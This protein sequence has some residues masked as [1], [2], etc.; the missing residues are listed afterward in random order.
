MGFIVVTRHDF[1]ALG[2]LTELMYFPGL[3]SSQ[4]CTSKGRNL[5]SAMR[6]WV[7]WPIS[8]KIGSATQPNEPAL[9]LDT[10]SPEE[11][12]IAQCM[13]AGIHPNNAATAAVPDPPSN[14]SPF[15]AFA[16][17][18]DPANQVPNL[19]TSNF[20]GCT[21]AFNIAATSVKLDPVAFTGRRP[22]Q[23]AHNKALGVFLM[24][25]TPGELTMPVRL[26]C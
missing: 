18:P 17:F 14:S 8:Q 12:I 11:A 9:D 2:V 21:S 25:G 13:L 26:S 4:Q 20:P 22:Q 15:E 3:F 1:G 6:F 19:Q 24:V 7:D 23:P 16:S 10:L 5:Y